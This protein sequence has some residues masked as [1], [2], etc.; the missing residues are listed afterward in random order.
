MG[1]ITR[2][3]AREK[4]KER[5]KE[6]KKDSNTKEKEPHQKPACLQLFWDKLSRRMPSLA[7]VV[8]LRRLDKRIAAC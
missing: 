3:S 2:Q 6:V 1:L 7:R 4:K 8:R 5:K